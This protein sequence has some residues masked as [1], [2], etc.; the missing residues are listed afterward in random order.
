[1]STVNQICT[2]CRR[3]VLWLGPDTVLWLAFQTGLIVATQGVL[4]NGLST[5][6]V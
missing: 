3:A 2:S 5:R 1:M 6:L 4:M